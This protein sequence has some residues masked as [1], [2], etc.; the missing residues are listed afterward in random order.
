LSCIHAEE[1]LTAKAI[2]LMVGQDKAAISRALKKLENEGHVTP[3]RAKTKGGVTSRMVPYCLTESGTA[4]YKEM[5]SIAQV[6]QQILQ[7]E[8]SPTER[9]QFTDYLLRIQ[10]R[11]PLLTD[12]MD[13]IG[14]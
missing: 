10:K 5:L 13:N 4:L 12:E 3:T 9:E 14:K 2:C 11:L 1:S 7:D 8:F 6:R